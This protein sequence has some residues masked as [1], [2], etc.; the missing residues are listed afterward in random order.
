MN[1]RCLPNC[2]LTI[3]YCT[4][5][6]SDNINCSA[7]T[8]PYSLVGGECKLDCETHDINAKTCSVTDIDII[9]ECYQNYTLDTYNNQCIANCYL[10]NPNCKDCSN[11]DNRMCD[12]CRSIINFELKN[13]NCFQNC[14]Y[15]DPNAIS[16]SSNDITLI[17]EC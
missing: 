11:I 6:H 7:C 14:M 2:L 4:N 12:S 17:Q 10:I 1:T 5:C 16:C 9:E 13:Y 3:P 8:P 15:N